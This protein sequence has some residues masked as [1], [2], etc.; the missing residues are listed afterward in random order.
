M[1][2]RLDGWARSH[3]ARL[4][5]DRCWVRLSNFRVVDA[6]LIGTE[7]VPPRQFLSTSMTWPSD[8]F[9]VMVTLEYLGDR[10]GAQ[11]RADVEEPEQETKPPKRMK[12]ADS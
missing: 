3:S 8:H 2:A 11:K 5:Y 9:G 6:A 12:V 10:G 7:P 4:R 1:M